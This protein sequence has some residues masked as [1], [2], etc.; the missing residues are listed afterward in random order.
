MIL[1]PVDNS[2][3][4]FYLFVYPNVYLMSCQNIFSI[5]KPRVFLSPNLCQTQVIL[6][7]EWEAE[8]CWIIAI[9]SGFGWEVLLATSVVHREGQM[10]PQLRTQKIDSFQKK[11]AGELTY[12]VW[13]IILRL[14][15]LRQISSVPHQ[16]QK[17]FCP[18]SIVLWCAG[19]Q[20]AY[21]DSDKLS[22]DV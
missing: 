13:E 8:M 4:P 11:E 19:I 22:W 1:D 10:P 12:R 5:W 16:C 3:L 9:K 14:W 18:C 6:L 21:L 20:T 15:S 7:P 2:H 17:S